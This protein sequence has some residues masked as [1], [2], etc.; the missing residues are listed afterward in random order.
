VYFNPSAEDLIWKKDWLDDSNE[1]LPAVQLSTTYTKIRL[2]RCSHQ[3]ITIRLNYYKTINLVYPSGD[4][5]FNFKIEL[6]R[7]VD[8][9]PFSW[10]TKWFEKKP[11]KKKKI[12]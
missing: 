11:P 4:Y 9:Q 6:T 7:W 8:S 5:D 10:K 3:P 1:Y 2:G 12:V